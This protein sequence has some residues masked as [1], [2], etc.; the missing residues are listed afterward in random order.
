MVLTLVMSAGGL[1][2]AEAVSNNSLIVG[3]AVVVGAAIVP[4]PLP[5]ADASIT[6][7]TTNVTVF[8]AWPL[9]SIVKFNCAHTIHPPPAGHS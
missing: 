5:Q 8:M 4:E 9:G 2:T 7:V 3:A 1:V 6:I